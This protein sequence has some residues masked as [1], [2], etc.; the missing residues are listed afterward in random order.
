MRCTN[1]IIEQGCPVY[2]PTY[3]S[4]SFFC[5]LY[6]S[7]VPRE[8]NY[9]FRITTEGFCNAGPQFPSPSVLNDKRHHPWAVA[10]L[11]RRLRTDIPFL[12]ISNGRQIDFSLVERSVLPTSM[13]FLTAS[14]SSGCYRKTV[15]SLAFSSV[16]NFDG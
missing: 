13:N 2:V 1:M 6:Q 12:F 5:D 4:N 7:S 14:N 16:L 8:D 10:E 3:P 9:F 15:I 11:F